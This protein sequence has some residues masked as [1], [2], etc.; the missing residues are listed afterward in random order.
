METNVTLNAGITQFLLRQLPLS[1]NALDSLNRFPGRSNLVS[2]SKDGL[3]SSVGV[4]FNSLYNPHIWFSPFVWIFGEPDSNLQILEYILET[5]GDGFVCMGYKSDI[6]FP[7]NLLSKVRYYNEDLMIFSRASMFN[8]TEVTDV[9]RLTPDDAIDSILLSHPQSDRSTL[10]KMS[11]SERRFIEEREVFGI[12]VG[13]VLVSRGAI[14][15]T[16][17][18]FSAVGG[19]VTGQNH[20]REGFGRQIVSFLVERVLSSRHRPFL[21]VRSDNS[22]AIA[23]YG[24][25]GFSKLTEVVYLDHLSNTRP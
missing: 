13:K 12:H 25:L 3:I 23:L 19:F 4:I 15:S 16:F 6:Q 7:K 24:S 22:P 1:S 11:I 20:R 5:Q 9:V 2:V 10:E 21:T 14:M 17:G 8:G 18:N